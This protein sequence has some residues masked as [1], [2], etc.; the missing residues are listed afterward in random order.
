MKEKIVAPCGIDCF[1]CEVYE[2]NVTPQ[3]QERLS[4][5]TKLPKD[6]I[7]CAGC[8]ADNQCLFLKIQNKSCKT[9]DCAH[10][11]MVDYCFNCSDFPCDLLMP[12]ADGA[13]KYPHNIK[14]FNL[15]T[16]QRIGVE[17]WIDQAKNIRHTYFTKVF[18]IGD[19]GRKD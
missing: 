15:C 10:E 3:L 16:M 4:L 9:R 13:A 8:T 7:S 6:Q 11:K 14:L 2:D 1:N 18:L 12:I 19:G 17:K 5:M